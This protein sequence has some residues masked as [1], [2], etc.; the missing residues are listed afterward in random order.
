MELSQN[1]KA[2]LQETGEGAVALNL[3]VRL[4]GRAGWSVY[5][6]YTE[7]GCDVII[8]RAR[9]GNLQIEVKTRQTLLTKR[10]N[11]NTCHFTLTEGE[12]NACD[13]LI[14][15]WFDRHA[16]FIVPK[17]DL[18]RTSSN[19]RPLYKFIAH[20]SER[21]Q[22]YTGHCA[23]FI[24]RWDQIFGLRDRNGPPLER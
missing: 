10:R 3:A 24:E 18:R 12:R 4:Y 21:Q 6:N 11:R 13:Y 22:K 5:R 20:W 9:K 19:G 15:Y 8:Q 1:L 14:A 17:A 7:A 23:W 16:Y 2:L